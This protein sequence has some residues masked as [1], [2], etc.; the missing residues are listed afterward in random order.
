MGLGG[1][2]HAGSG[3]VFGILALCRE[4]AWLAPVLY[5]AWLVSQPSPNRLLLASLHLPL[6][7]SASSQLEEL[8]PNRLCEYLYTLSEVFSAFY[9]E[10][11][12]RLHGGGWVRAGEVV[13]VKRPLTGCG[14]CCSSA[15]IAADP[16]PAALP[17]KH[18]LRRAAGGGQRRGGQPAHALRGHGHGHAPVLQPAGHHA[19]VQDLSTLSPQAGEACRRAM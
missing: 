10:C 8:L 11:K 7:P 15:A 18:V 9:T 1:A 5:L 6:V 16:Q 17:D 4:R 2:K 19:P 12:V 3:T 13:R 14:R